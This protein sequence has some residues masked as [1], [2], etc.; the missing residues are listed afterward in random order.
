MVSPYPYCNRRSI[1]LSAIAF[2]GIPFSANAG[3]TPP[4]TVTI[5]DPVMLE[6]ATEPANWDVQKDYST[7]TVPARE[8]TEYCDLKLFPYVPE[9]M[10][11]YSGLLQ[12]ADLNNAPNMV[13]IQ[14]FLFTDN[15]T[16]S[17]NLPIVIDEVLALAAEKYFLTSTDALTIARQTDT[18]FMVTHQADNGAS[19]ALL[20]VSKDNRILVLRAGAKNTNPVDSLPGMVTG[21]LSSQPATPA[22]GEGANVDVDWEIEGWRWNYGPIDI[23]P[24]RYQSPVCPAS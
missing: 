10:V 7:T 14:E 17:L 13:L 9:S 4:S 15:E 20:V 8:P 18:E 16:A 3:Q 23:H 2:A 22:G 5:I 24:D 11:A 21:I 1:V 6:P 19:Y 12:A